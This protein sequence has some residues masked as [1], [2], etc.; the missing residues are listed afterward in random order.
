MVIVISH[1]WTIDAE[2]H[3]DAYINFSE[4]FAQ[5]FDDHPGFIRRVLVRGQEDRTHFMNMRFFDK[6]DSY[7]ECTQREG[8]VAYTEKMYEHMKPYESY[9]REF[10][11]VVLDTGPSN[12][13]VDALT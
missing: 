4:G 1:A 10:V 5:L 6:V 12:D 8:Y 7:L 13:V 11:D 9:P 3:A 2:E